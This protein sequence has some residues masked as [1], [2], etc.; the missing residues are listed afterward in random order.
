M[1]AAVVLVVS[2][3][4]LLLWFQGNHNALAIYLDGEHFGYITF[5]EEIE[6]G[7]LRVEAVRRLESIVDAR[8]VVNEAV[9][10]RPAN[11]APADILPHGEAIERLAA[12]FE[13]QIRGMAI[14]VNGRQRAVLRNEADAEN[15]K[16]ELMRPF[17]VSGYNHPSQFH[18]AGFLENV[19]M[20]SVTID[21]GDEHT[22]WEAIEELTGNIEMIE[23]YVIQPNDNLGSIALR[24]DTTVAQIVEDNP[25]TT[26]ATILRVGNTLRIRSTR[27][28]LSVRIVQEIT[29]TEP[30][31]MEIQEQVNP[32]A[33]SGTS[34]IIR[35]GS[36]GERE[37]VEHVTWINGIQANVEVISTRMVREMVPQVVEVGTM[38]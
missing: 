5:S 17:F 18:E 15:V 34:Q 27:P 23:E 4:S 3:A 28:Y 14:E 6:A 10:L 26:E 32:G 8:V 37:I 31:I 20:V 19:Q 36:E 11:S 9:T 16:F 24:H 30:V 1:A 29:R 25:G 21:E 13:Y 22:V 7:H 12:A 2:L 33:S 38:D 35:E